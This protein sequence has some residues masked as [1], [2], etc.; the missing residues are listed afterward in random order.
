MKKTC[1][2]YLVVWDFN[3]DVKTSRVL[4]TDEEV[5]K[6]RAHI[7]IYEV[8]HLET[9]AQYTSLDGVESLLSISEE[10]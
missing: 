7:A 8:I 2:E 5:D 1:D 9:I 4:A 6:L 3:G 10:L